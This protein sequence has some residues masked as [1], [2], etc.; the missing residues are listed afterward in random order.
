MTVPLLLVAALWRRLA[1]GGLFRP[2]TRRLDHG[3]ELAK[4]RP[5]TKQ[6]FHE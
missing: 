3:N 1:P 6:R 2:A 4:R 5:L